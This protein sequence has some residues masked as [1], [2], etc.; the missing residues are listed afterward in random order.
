MC[1]ALSRA[2]EGFYI[3][4]NMQDLIAQSELWSET[5]KVLLDQEAIGNSLALK[6]HIH[7]DQINQVF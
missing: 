4:G 5:N 2:R 7:P 3:M 6:C 1:V